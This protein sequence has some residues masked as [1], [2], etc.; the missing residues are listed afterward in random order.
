MTVALLLAGSVLTQAVGVAA[1]RATDGLRRPGWVALAFL[2]MAC[3][4]T[5]MARALH[6]GL[7]LAVGYGIWS[8]AGIAFAAISGTVLFGDRLAGRQIVGL[9]LVA[10]GVAATYGGSS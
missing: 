1:T 7:S 2:A 5:L 8:G 9:V 3:S 4:V 6:H 10:A